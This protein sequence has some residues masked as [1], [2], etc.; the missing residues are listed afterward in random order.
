MA[1][2]KAFEQACCIFEMT[3]GFP[4]EEKIFTNRSNTKIITFRLC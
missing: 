4:H 1:Y 3:I 2:K